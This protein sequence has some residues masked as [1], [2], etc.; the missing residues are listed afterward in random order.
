MGIYLAI[1]WT[2]LCIIFTIFVIFIHFYKNDSN[3]QNNK[4]LK[5]NEEWKEEVRK[6]LSWIYK[7]IYNTKK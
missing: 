6:K 2:Y 7:S 4:I 1:I 5:D 3:K